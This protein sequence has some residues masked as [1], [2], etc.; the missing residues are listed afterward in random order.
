VL[1]VR[2]SIC[3][4]TAVAILLGSGFTTR[5]VCGQSASTNVVVIDIPYIFKNHV[6]FK[7]AI[8]DIKKDIDAYKQYITKQQAQ[9]RAER[10]RLQQFKPGTR[11]YKEIEER[12][13]R[14]TM[15][16]QLEGAKQQKAFMEREAQEY[17]KAYKE[18]QDA[19]AE[20]AGRNGISLV[21]RYNS[22]E[23]DPSKRE[24]IMQG[25]NSMVVYQNG[26]N[27]TPLI[28]DRL[29][30]GTPQGPISSKPPIPRPRANYQR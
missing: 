6:R 17:Y 24:S 11:E 3:L 13:A 16:A 1:T 21:L 7:A 14:M 5:E 19:V 27:I 22:E 9:I 10:E 28:L 29:N 30:R 25:V 20:F 26:L 4:A 12:I 8:D 2:T 18:I 23:I 15:E